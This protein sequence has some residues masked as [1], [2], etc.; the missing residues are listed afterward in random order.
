M[1]VGLVVVCGLVV[2]VGFLVEAG[3]G[4]VVGFTLAV[5]F[6]VVAVSIS[7]LESSLLEVS[8]SSVSVWISS[9]GSSELSP[10]NV[11]LSVS[12]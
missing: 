8:S 6:T 4:V 11:K 10:V 2:A 5:G 7:K 9:M 1:A 3:F 12:S